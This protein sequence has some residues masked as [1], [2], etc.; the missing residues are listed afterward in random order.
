MGEVSAEALL[1]PPVDGGGVA[2]S[3][4]GAGFVW[5]EGVDSDEEEEDDDESSGGLDA[6]AGGFEGPQ[7]ARPRP[8]PKTEKTSSPRM[9]VVYHAARRLRSHLRGLPAVA[10]GLAPGQTGIILGA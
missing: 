8:R 9:A 10:R 5:V 7:A 1:P 4:D 6:S 3:L 2:S